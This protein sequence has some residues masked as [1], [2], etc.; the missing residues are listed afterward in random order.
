MLRPVCVG[1]ITAHPGSLWSALVLLKFRES[2]A[3]TGMGMTRGQE[4]AES[5]D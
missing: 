3:K 2:S 5:G 1:S 4:Q